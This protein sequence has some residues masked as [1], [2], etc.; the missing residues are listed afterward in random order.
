MWTFGLKI[1]QNAPI[2]GTTVKQS[3]NH[4]KVEKEKNW[5]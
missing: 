3:G 4:R 1:K 2:K 5:N